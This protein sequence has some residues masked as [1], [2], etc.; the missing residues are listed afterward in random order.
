MA[1]RQHRDHRLFAEKLEFEPAKSISSRGKPGRDVVA[2]EY[3]V[4]AQGFTNATAPLTSSAKVVP[5]IL[6]KTSRG[7]ERQRFFRSVERDHGG[8]DDIT[9]ADGGKFIPPASKCRNHV[10]HP[11]RHSSS[12]RRVVFPSCGFAGPTPPRGCLGAHT[13]TLPHYFSLRSDRMD[14]NLPP[15]LL[16]AR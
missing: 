10:G 9:P 8:R 1:R 4:T 5:A 7:D 2:Y 16:H 6:E 14:G 11:R 13:R 15:R 12:T 3:D